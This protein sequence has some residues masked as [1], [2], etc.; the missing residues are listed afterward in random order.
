MNT[1][2]SFEDLL[3]RCETEPIHT[4]GAIQPFGILLAVDLPQ[5]LIHNASVNCL[6]ALGVP[7]AELAGRSFA[8]LVGDG[9]LQALRDYLARNDLREQTP[10]V[11]Q[12]APPAAPA[13]RQCELTAHTHGDCLFIELE[14]YC[15]H[16]VDAFSFHL[17]IR[18]AVQALQATCSV[19][20]LCE[21]AVR[22]VQEITGF[23][24]VMLYRFEDDWH[25][26]VVAEARKP[27]MDA[28]LG[29]HFPG[30][31][32]P[33]QAR[34]VF[35]QNWLRMIPDV[36]YVPAQLYPGTSPRTGAPI[37]LGQ[38]MLRSVSPIHIEYLR[39]ME[40]KAT[41]TVSL[42]DGGKLWGL[43]ACHHPTPLLID[44]DSRLGAR[45]V[46]QLVSAQLQLKQ[47]LEDL[48]YRARLREV[49]QRLLS[50]MEQEDDLVHGLVKYSPNMLDLAAAQG[51]AAAIYH[52][53]KW[54][55]IGKTP[56]VEQIEELVSW[57]STRHANQGVYATNRLGKHFPP[58]LAYKNVASGLLA[59]SI[60]KTE[61]NYI[62]WFRPE[63]ATTITWAGRP[64]KTTVTREGDQVRLHPR[65]SFHSWQ[66]VVEGVSQPWEKV[67]I[68]TI[69]ELRNSILALDLRR[70]FRKEQQARARA[71]RI[72]GEKERMVHMVSHDLRSPLTV[73][74]MSLELLQHASMT[75]AHARTELVRRCLRATESME[76]L[77][78]DVL[79]M[80]KND[81]GT[82]VL[83]SMAENAE[84]MVKDAADM[85]QPLA[86]EKSIRI[87]TSLAAPEMEVLCERS[88]IAQ[89]FSNLIGN[90]LKFTPAGGTI[91]V[92]VE[93]QAEML[94]FCVADTGIGIPPEQQQRIFDRF[95]QE[96]HARRHGAGLGLSIAKAIV[97][98]HGGRIWV[99]SVA[100]SGSR[101]H[102]TLPRKRT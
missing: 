17:T 23:D 39:N 16:E 54:T 70:E 47:S 98:K 28:F 79:D 42:I 34:A 90:A 37:D 9:Q 76:R 19:Q 13:F 62:L 91:T 60:P 67:E 65:A 26:K 30:T 75:E 64:D 85:A 53:N 44:S 57:L 41:L 49:H 46:G 31:D 96:E 20:Q 59:V 15:T 61:R 18:E 4:P 14:P 36:D 29:H 7:A 24:R 3:A 99:D 55:I 2:H 71:E 72:S 6:E 69:A 40:V 77:A 43:I 21:E 95:Y 5:L 51:A 35:L 27:H 1:D 100:G 82:L 33:A 80:A 87:Q 86:A 94:A 88:R 92:S 66:E 83:A 84:C 68:E 74:R 32:I 102:F 73:V 56:S 22:R 101:F 81:A 89:V 58:A 63:I 93:A 10:L 12:L 45:M 8:E 50:Y 97:E 38:A 52:D 25:G 11:I 78:N 48:Q